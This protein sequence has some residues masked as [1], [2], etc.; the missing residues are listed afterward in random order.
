MK[1]GKNALRATVATLIIA[2]GIGML[3]PA[4]AADGSNANSGYVT[5]GFDRPVSDGADN[6]VGDASLPEGATRKCSTET[7]AMPVAEPGKGAST[8]EA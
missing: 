3:A 7:P 8:T 6:C 5:D 4:L 1:H 2:G